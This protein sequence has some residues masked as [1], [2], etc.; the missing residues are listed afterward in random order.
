MVVKFTCRFKTPSMFSM[1]MT[2]RFVILDMDCPR[3][4]SRAWNESRPTLSKDVEN[5]ASPNCM[6]GEYFISALIAFIMLETSFFDNFGACFFTIHLFASSSCVFMSRCSF[7]FK[8]TWAP[9]NTIPCARQRQWFTM[10]TN[11]I[12]LHCFVI[13]GMLL[14][15]QFKQSGLKETSQQFGIIN[16]EQ[17]RIRLGQDFLEVLLH[18]FLFLLLQFLK[19][20]R[21][22]CFFVFRC[23]MG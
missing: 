8:Q 1:L 20:S 18:P 9:I 10:Q 17:L 22:S 7:L 19:F 14:P 6:D 3:T 21:I 15:T 5:L 2:E 13:F 11:S 16:G 12:L 23:D 4:T